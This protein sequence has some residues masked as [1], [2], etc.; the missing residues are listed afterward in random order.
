MCSLYSITTPTLGG[1]LIIHH[2]FRIKGDNFPLGFFGGLL[3]LLT[4][5]ELQLQKRF[6]FMAST[7]KLHFVIEAMFDFV[8]C[9]KDRAKMVGCP[10]QI[11]IFDCETQGIPHMVIWHLKLLVP[12]WV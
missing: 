5:A 12:F 6:T 8:R 9:K 2:H 3:Q 11:A 7:F 1:T 10:H 4:D